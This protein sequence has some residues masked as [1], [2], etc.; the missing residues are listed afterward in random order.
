[1][2]K[3]FGERVVCIDSTHKSTGYDFLLI[4]V[5]VVDEFGE[6]YPVA[7]CLCNKEDQILMTR[8]GNLCTWHIDRAWRQAL[9][10]LHERK[11]MYSVLYFTNVI[12]Y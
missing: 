8:V 1:M 3:N 5:V 4:T 7:W 6:G 12:G 11:Q 10:L 9:G 2:L